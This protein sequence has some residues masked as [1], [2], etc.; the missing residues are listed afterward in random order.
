M[1]HCLF[2][3]LTLQISN[4]SHVPTHEQHKITALLKS[5][6][7][8]E[9]ALARVR[10]GGRKQRR[11]RSAPR[12][13]YAL[14]RRSRNADKHEERANR[15]PTNETRLKSFVIYAVAA[16]SVG[17]GNAALG[18]PSLP[19]SSFPPPSRPFHSFLP[20]MNWKVFFR[21]MRGLHFHFVLRFLATWI[22]M[23]TIP[24]PQRQRRRREGR[25]EG[26]SK[27]RLF[28]ESLLRKRQRKPRRLILL[29][30]L[31]CWV[32]SLERCA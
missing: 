2:N 7:P 20:S 4:K 28:S 13:P 23:H 6:H 26:G 14:M 17:G 29:L 27:Q 15:E 8:S 3:H 21:K 10:E 30:R 16:R 25:R 12:T 5:P 22:C 32:I 18:Y 19:R 24:H 9:S 31:L 1:R 11:P